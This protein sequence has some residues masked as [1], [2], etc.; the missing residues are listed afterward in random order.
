M[1]G[2]MGRHMDAIPTNEYLQVCVRAAGVCTQE[3]KS[4]LSAGGCLHPVGVACKK[5]LHTGGR[6]RIRRAGLHIG[7][8][9]HTVGWRWQFTPRAAEHA[10]GARATRS[11]PGRSGGSAGAWGGRLGREAIPGAGAVPGPC[12][13]GRPGKAPLTKGG[14]V[15]TPRPR[16][17]RPP[18]GAGGRETP[19]GQPP[20]RTPHPPAGRPQTPR[21][22]G[23]RGRLA[24]RRT[25]GGRQPAP[26]TP[27]R[28]GCAPRAHRRGRWR[29]SGGPH[30]GEN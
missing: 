19:P 10:P 24:P 4:L 13:P 29:G 17:G 3:G 8:G 20:A 26:G 12:A 14:S 15:Q 5:G 21:L 7:G 27:E 1:V 6:A 25:R 28:T 30:S 22:A 23:T 11:R 18:P 9:L 2:S 16:P